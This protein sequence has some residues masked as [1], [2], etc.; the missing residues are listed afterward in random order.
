MCGKRSTG[1]SLPSFF[2]TL[3]EEQNVSPFFSAVCALFAQKCR[4]VP[5]L[6]LLRR[7]SPRGQSGTRRPSPPA[8]TIRHLKFPPFPTTVCPHKPVRLQ[9]QFLVLLLTLARRV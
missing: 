6:F 3:S 7:L 1:A 4:G 5:P 8:Q 2:A 9:V